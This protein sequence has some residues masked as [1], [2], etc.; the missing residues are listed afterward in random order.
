MEPTTVNTFLDRFLQV[1]DSGF[2]LIQ[3]DV[4]AVMTPLARIHC[5]VSGEAA[6]MLDTSQ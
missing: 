4:S 3:G 1:A 6:R 2:G 5:E